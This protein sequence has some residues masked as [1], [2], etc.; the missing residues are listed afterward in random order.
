M[1]LGYFWFKSGLRYKDISQRADKPGNTASH[2]KLGPALLSQ[3][4]FLLLL[5]PKSH[6]EDS[7]LPTAL[8]KTIEIP[9]GCCSL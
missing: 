6:R 7:A 1:I 5:L 8:T 2:H 3:I 4:K 9:A